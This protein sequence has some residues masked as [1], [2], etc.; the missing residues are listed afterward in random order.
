MVLALS[1]CCWAQHETEKSAAAKRIIKPTGWQIPGRVE[2]ESNEPARRSNTVIDGKTVEISVWTPELIRKQQGVCNAVPI[3][4][5]AR[6][7]DRTL[8]YDEV[9]AAAYRV[10]RF[11]HQRQA[12][13]YEVEAEPCSRG[14]RVA[15]IEMIAFYDEDG[16]GCFET[17]E[18][19]DTRIPP[20]EPWRPRLT[21]W[22][23]D[24]AT[25]GPV[26]CQPAKGRDTL[27]G[28]R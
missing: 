16:D 4:R 10:R 7:Y 13:L 24:R 14:S 15:E 25:R 17:L 20:V 19:K 22:V 11:A 26:R 5:F 12:F 18:Y 8:E 28:S 27:N 1:G 23:V 6:F 9:W 3:P 2:V 21:K